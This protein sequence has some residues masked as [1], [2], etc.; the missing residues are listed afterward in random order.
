MVLYDSGRFIN[1]LISK[2]AK[3]LVFNCI[4][5]DRVKLLF[6]SQQM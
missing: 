6:V 3:K 1:F 4:Y 2:Y 5:G